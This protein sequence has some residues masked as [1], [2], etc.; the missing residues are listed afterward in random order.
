MFF[1][2]RTLW[3][4][5]K[6]ISVCCA[7]TK[8]GNWKACT[9]ILGTECCERL[10]Y[11]G[12]ASNLV[13]YL[14]NTLQEGNVSAARNVTNWKCTCYLTPLIGAII[15]D[16]YLGKYL[17]ISIFSTICF[18]GMCT[19][20]LSA[21]IPA[22]KPVECEGSLCPSATTAQ[23]AVFFLG[24]YL[25]AL[26]TGCIKP[27]VS[28]F[29]ADQFDDTDPRERVKKGSFFNWFY[30]CINDGALISSEELKIL[31]RMFPIWATGI[32]FAAILARMSTMF[33]EQRMTMAYDSVIVHIAR[34]FTGTDRGFS[35]L[36]RMGIG[37]I[38]SV[39][40]MMAAAIVEIK[41]FKLAREL[42]L[43]DQS[44][45]VPLC[46]LWKIP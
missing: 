1:L 20:T 46:I 13:S 37:L 9:F 42:G 12:I 17:T 11:Y 34:K 6:V 24:L 10:A 40:C 5:R 3:P 38:L 23:Y 30:F 19:L 33:V 27:C 21:T 36:Q 14:T 16:A 2:M 29:G 15:A 4:V 8:T 45:A 41:R 35:Q 31:V 18:I 39:L 44:V 28:S 26:G 43:V 22:L 25:V 32:V 7:S